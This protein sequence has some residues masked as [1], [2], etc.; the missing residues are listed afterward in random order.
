MQ[1]VILTF[2]EEVLCEVE[3]GTVAERELA[4]FLHHVF[5]SLSQS[6]HQLHNVNDAVTPVDLLNPC[7]DDTERACA[8][9]AV[10]ETDVDVDGC[11]GQN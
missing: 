6:L 3:N 2:H 4:L 9:N 11:T 10:A 5:A 7:V 8:T 1:E